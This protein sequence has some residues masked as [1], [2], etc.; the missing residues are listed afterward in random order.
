MALVAQLARRVRLLRALGLACGAV[1]A[2][3]CSGEVVNL[4]SS[5]LQAGGAGAGGMTGG[6]DG[7]WDVPSQPL[8]PQTRNILLANPTLT[9]AMDELFYS[10]QERG[11]DPDPHRSRVLRVTRVGTGWSP[12]VEQ[13]L[14]DWVAPDVSSPA[15]SANGRELWLGRNL[16]GSTDVFH[17]A[18]QDG[19][20]TTPQ[21][22]PELSS[23]DFDDV[24]RPP[25]VN[26]TI[27]PLSSKRHGGVL[28]LYQIYLS[29]RASNDAVWGEPSRAL[30]GAVDSDAFQ[31]ADGFLSDNGLELYFSSTRD[32]DHTDADLYVARRA[33][34]DA[35]FGVPEALVD[36]NDPDS[37]P[38]Q[39]R[40]PWLSPT[41]DRLYF[42]SDRSGQYTLYEANKL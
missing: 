9:A 28:P 29:T 31:S 35:A 34:L 26:G 30:L 32:G 13:I 24:P 42:V 7:V 2:S 3:G 37:T 1:V 14:G 19:A 18:R 36:L 10:E 33:T 41:G 27:M 8:L 6:P 16:T 40:M 21:L 38:A 5:S 4:G 25:A 15:V 23:A 11:A 39:E 20:W 12:P 22:V 17:S